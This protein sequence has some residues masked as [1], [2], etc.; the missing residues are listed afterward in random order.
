MSDT[1]EPSTGVQNA[2]S[3]RR[4]VLKRLLVGLGASAILQ[5]KGGVFALA[6]TDT[7]KQK[8]GKKKKGSQGG[9]TGGK[10]KAGKKKGKKGTDT[11]EKKN[12]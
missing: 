12:Q 7:N 8:G 4:D 11:T 1:R 3:S 9:K 6:Q 2:K 5:P 10:S